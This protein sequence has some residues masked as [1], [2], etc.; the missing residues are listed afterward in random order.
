MENVA[1]HFIWAAL[2]LALV[3]V[4]MLTLTFILLS[5]GVA[6][7]IVALLSF[8][9]LTNIW[10]QIA[11]FAVFGLFVLSLIKK[12]KAS[13]SKE[14]TFKADENRS[15]VL[16]SAMQNAI[17]PGEEG[18]VSYQGSP[19]TAVNQGQT[20]LSAGQKVIIL[21]TQGIK[22]FIKASSEV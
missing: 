20:P 3:V 1:L 9:G 11:L 13:E 17:L 5:F 12:K 2:G 19:W 14:Q 16:D 6:A 22:I 8:L 18:T 10:I 7:F 4:E 15:F 21:K